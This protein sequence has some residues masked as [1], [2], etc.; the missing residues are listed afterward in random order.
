[1]LTPDELREK[2]SVAS[3]LL[4]WPAATAAIGEGSATLR[5]LEASSDTTIID[6][7]NIITDYDTTI[8]RYY[9]TTLLYFT[10]LRFYTAIPPLTPAGLLGGWA[11]RGAAAGRAAGRGAADGV[12]AAETV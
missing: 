7:D 12:R 8:L 4:K 10:I 2:H 1:M 11:L 6:H 9:D 3:S 5:H